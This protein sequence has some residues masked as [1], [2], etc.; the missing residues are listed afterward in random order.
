VFRFRT[1]I[2]VTYGKQ[3]CLPPASCWGFLIRILGW[4]GWTESTQHVGYWMTYCTCPRWFWW[5]R[6]WCNEDSQAKPKYSEKTCPITT[7]STTNPTC[8]IRARTW[9]AA[10]GSH[11]LT[12]WAMA[13]R[14]MLVSC[15]AYSST[16]RWHVPTKYNGL[17]GDISQKTELYPVSVRVMAN[18]TICATW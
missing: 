3:R 2:S 5:W 14:F 18:A 12:A 8:Q 17:H 4:G 1:L 11:R 10:V 6:I 13:R 15:L 16:W 9:A 7:L